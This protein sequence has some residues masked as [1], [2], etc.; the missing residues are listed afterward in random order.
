MK[1]DKKDLKAKNEIIKNLETELIN[2]QQ[3]EIDLAEMTNK[4]QDLQAKVNSKA[5]NECVEHL[6]KIS[7]LTN[8][9]NCLETDK[10]VLQIQN[11]N[12][13]EVSKTP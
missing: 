5:H 7:E 3:L 8:T 4:L 6:K 9:V 2:K 12:L 10:E 13:D 11:E 1:Q